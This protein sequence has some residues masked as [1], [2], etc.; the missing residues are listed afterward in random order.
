[1]KVAE[2]GDRETKNCWRGSDD[3]GEAIWIFI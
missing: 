1:M 2:A 3:C